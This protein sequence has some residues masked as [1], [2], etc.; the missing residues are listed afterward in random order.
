MGLVNP[1]IPENEAKFFKELLGLDVFVETGTYIG[2]SVKKMSYL[3]QKVYTIE[4]SEIMFNI[5]AN[6][7]K[8]I[9]NAILL[10][11]DSREFLDFILGNNDNILFWLDAHWSG[12]ETYG[13]EDECPLL[14]KL[15]TIFRY[16][17]N[18]VVL[19][20]DARL[21]VAPP[22][23]PHKMENWPS[24]KDIARVMPANWEIIMFEDVFYLYN[25][26]HIQQVKQYFQDLITQRCNEYV[27]G[28]S[29]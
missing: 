21:F 18:C 1:G 17:K 13:Q 5:A 8:S 3:F 2:N 7:L 20:D 12:E 24:L 4:K 28:P 10:K 6:N 15:Q 16:S 9:E 14:E 27:K 23:R 11:G 25:I 22:P 19:I 29:A 26:Q